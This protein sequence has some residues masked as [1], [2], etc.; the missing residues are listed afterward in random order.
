[1]AAPA[2]MR[3]HVDAARVLQQRFAVEPESPAQFPMH[4][5][6]PHSENETLRA[7]GDLPTSAR[8]SRDGIDANG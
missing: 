5:G 1:M 6:F 8:L 7:R 3:R 2:R 4:F